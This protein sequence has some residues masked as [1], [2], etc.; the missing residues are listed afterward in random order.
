M[1][2]DLVTGEKRSMNTIEY[3]RREEGW[4][5][6]KYNLCGKKARWFEE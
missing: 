6:K 5:V 2:L 3:H 4:V 1:K